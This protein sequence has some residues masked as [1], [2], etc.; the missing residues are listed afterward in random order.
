MPA[1]LGLIFFCSIAVSQNTLKDKFVYRNNTKINTRTHVTTAMFSVNSKVYSGSPESMAKQFLQENKE[2]FGI[3]DTSNIKHDKTVES[4]G[5]K[6]VIFHETY[7]GIPVYGSMTK[8]S[9]NKDNRVTSV[10]NGNIPVSNLASTTVAIDKQSAVGSAFVKTQT[11]GKRLSIQPAINQYIYEDSIHQFHNTWRVNFV[12]SHPHKSWQVFVDANTGEVL[13]ARDIAQYIDGQGRVFKPDPITALRDTSL[14]DHGDSDYVALQNAYVTVTLNNLNDP[15]NGIYRLQGKYAKSIDIDFPYTEPVTSTTPSFLYNRSQPG[16]EE[17]NAYYF[18]DLQRQYVGGLGFTPQWNGHDSLCFDAHGYV[19]ESDTDNSAYD[20]CTTKS[21]YDPYFLYMFFGPGGIDDAEDQDVILHEYGHALHDALMEGDLISCADDESIISE[22][23]G[24]YMALSYRRTLSTFQRDHIFNWDGNG[25]S[26]SG[27]SISSS[28]NYKNDWYIDI[29]NFHDCHDAG[30]V[31]ASTMMD[32]EEATSKDVATTLLLKSF[33]YANP[34]FT[35]DEHINM[36]FR[37]D[38]D[39]YNGAHSDILFDVF[40]KRGFPFEFVALIVDQKLNSGTTSGIMKYWTGNSFETLSVLPDTIGVAIN[41]TQTFQADQRIVSN[42]KFN[43]WNSGSYFTNHHTFSI[44][45]KSITLTSNFI[46]TCNATLKAQLY[47]CGTTGDTVNFKDPWYDDTTDAYGTRNRGLTA[48]FNSVASGTNNLGT[49]TAYKGVFLNQ[50]ISSSSPYYSVS[51]PK[52]QTINGFT[53]YFQGWTKS[54]SSASFGD[55]TKDTTAVVFNSSGATVTAKYKAHLASNNT[56]SYKYFDFYYYTDPATPTNGDGQQR[57]ASTFMGGSNTDWE[58]I[59]VYASAGEIW[60]TSYDWITCIWSPEKRLSDGKGGNSQPSI[61]ARGKCTGYSF[62]DGVYVVW[63]K[64]RSDGQ[65]DVYF[66]LRKTIDTLNVGPN[67]R[68][69]ITKLPC[70]N[71]DSAFVVNTT[72]CTVAPQPVVGIQR[73]NSVVVSTPA[74]EYVPIVYFQNNTTM[75]VQYAML[76]SWGGLFDG[77]FYPSQAR[78]IIYNR[79]SDVTDR[80]RS[81]SITHPDNIHGGLDTAVIAYTEGGDSIMVKTVECISSVSDEG[82][83]RCVLGTPYSIRFCD[84]RFLC[85]DFTCNDNANFYPNY[86]LQ[87]M[88]RNGKTSCA[89]AVYQYYDVDLCP[90]VVYQDLTDTTQYH[91]WRIA[92]SSV[93]L[94]NDDTNTVLQWSTRDSMY[95]VLDTNWNV[96]RTIGA[97]HDPQM[98]YLGAAYE[99]EPYS[100]KDRYLCCQSGSSLWSVGV[101]ENEPLTTNQTQSMSSPIKAT[102]SLSVKTGSSLSMGGK[103]KAISTQGASITCSY[104]RMLTITNPGTKAQVSITMS[105]PKLGTKTL[106]FNQIPDTIT[107]DNCM[108]CLYTKASTVGS[109]D[110]TLS[111][112]VSMRSRNLETAINSI[113]CNVTANDNIVSTGRC[114]RDSKTHYGGYMMSLPVKDYARKSIKT[115]LDGIDIKS[116]GNNLQFSIGNIHTPGTVMQTKKADTSLIKT[117]TVNGLLGSYPNPFNPSTTISYQLA[118]NS[119][120]SLKVY[121][122]LGRQVATLVDGNK[123][124][125]Q[126][127]SVF[128]GS[129][130]ASGVYFV[131]LIVQGSNTQPTVKT[132]K[133]QMLK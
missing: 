58:D 28:L 77:C 112:K 130:Y 20:T 88:R 123:E 8:I 45:A 19:D 49:S 35:V 22:G 84:G 55:S 115:V 75:K 16:F 73:D 92:A 38:S 100:L 14:K 53:S 61:V 36:F 113:A 102:A 6:H 89:W 86:S 131:R 114:E 41:T 11:V 94:G 46:P 65:Y 119:R 10:S 79:R 71:I 68:G 51:A 56:P 90:F 109:T 120:I 117:S 25:E 9:I 39:L 43:N 122:M 37:A 125:G 24:D 7:M 26:W 52:T 29:D 34:N 23:S 13:E 27:R 101:P 30:L 21:Y 59:I 60:T 87:V 4:H 63:Q 1:G 54:G 31:W 91:I 70:G 74:V 50:S 124:A 103:S 42:Q 62:G 82:T 12:S 116:L 15:V 40:N 93:S 99:R 95:Q 33:E 72:P 47:E 106:D 132:L 118:A 98:S 3:S 5:V 105:Q 104:S 17:T 110:D 67:Y 97:Y 66:A 69:W 133:I 126:Y 44:A 111:F 129:R 64:L 57:I 107:A 32:L 76:S 128:D 96:I 108:Q 81:V 85:D 2:S 121:D 127:T 78:S 80:G 18:I 48:V 83:Q